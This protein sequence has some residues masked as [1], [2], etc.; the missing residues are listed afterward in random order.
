MTHKDMFKRFIVKLFGIK[1]RHLP[2]SELKITDVT[3]H[4]SLK[5]C[6]KVRAQYEIDMGDFK[7]YP[8]ELSHEVNRKLKEDLI[9]QL[10]EKKLIRQ[11]I[12]DDYENFK[13]IIKVEIDVID[14]NKI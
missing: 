5:P 14:I 6:V 12:F 11:A 10:E 13:K 7:A 3:I 8:K 1:G 2:D 4:R 9:S